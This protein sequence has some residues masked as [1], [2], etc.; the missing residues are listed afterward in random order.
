ARALH[1]LGNMLWWLGDIDQARRRYEE[2]GILARALGDRRT[3][4]WALFGQ[5]M[6]GADGEKTAIAC[7]DEAL[8]LFREIGDQPA[9]PLALNA[10]GIACSKAG[11]YAEARAAYEE[12]A[13]FERA[14]AGETSFVAG[15]ICNIGF[16]DARQGDW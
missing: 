12:A 9:I 2:A 13:A 15:M 7:G 14:R 5:A 10:I 8:T 3:L 16:N 1:V 11:L 4:G 6:S